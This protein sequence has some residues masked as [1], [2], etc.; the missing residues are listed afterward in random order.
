MEKYTYFHFTISCFINAILLIIML[1]REKTFMD[2]SY[3]SA[4]LRGAWQL[5]LSG[6]IS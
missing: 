1:K 6:A 3:E 2:I 5:I 4:F